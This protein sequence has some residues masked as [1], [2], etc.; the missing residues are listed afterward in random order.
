MFNFRSGG[1]PLPL[2][3]HLSINTE[4]RQNVGPI[5]QHGFNESAYTLSNN[6]ASVFAL[7]QYRH[8]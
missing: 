5:S 4:Q 2:A 1:A 3:S 8:N 6:Q 7:C